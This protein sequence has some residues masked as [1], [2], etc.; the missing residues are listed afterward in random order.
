[1]K[2]KKFPNLALLLYKIKGECLMILAL[3]FVNYV[4]AALYASERK[5]LLSEPPSQ[6]PLLIIL[7]NE[8]AEILLKLFCLPVKSGKIYIY[9]NLIRRT[10]TSLGRNKR[11]ELG[12]ESF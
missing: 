4:P 12:A 6:E 9:L 2:D 8:F 11:S 3:D 10:S 5:G 1:M 7:Q